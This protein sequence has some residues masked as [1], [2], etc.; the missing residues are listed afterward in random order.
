M[1]V[2][3]GGPGVVPV[4][5]YNY[6]APPVISSPQI[7]RLSAPPVGSALPV[8]TVS[9][10]I[11]PCVSPCVIPSP[12]IASVAPNAKIVT[13]NSPNVPVVVAPN[14]DVST[15]VFNVNK[16]NINHYCHTH[17]TS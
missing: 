5:Y 13:Y 10:V 7:A 14:Q 3:S 12:G 4:E 2:Q 1:F 16:N 17:K 8:Q 9:N 15:I 11:P 6:G